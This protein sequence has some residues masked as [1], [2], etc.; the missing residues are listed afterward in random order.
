MLAA[1]HRGIDASADRVADV[2]R[3]L[4]THVPRPA[5]P[6]IVRPMRSAWWIVPFAICLAVEWWMRRRRGLL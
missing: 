5:V 1:S 3:F 6:T 2:V 4:D